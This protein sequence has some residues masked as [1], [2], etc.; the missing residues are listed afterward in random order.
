MWTC[1]KHM[2]FS[3]GSKGSW[4]TEGW[5]PGISETSSAGT[6]VLS[7]GSVNWGRLLPQD[8]ASGLEDLFLLVVIQEAKSQFSKELIPERQ[9]QNDS[10]TPPTTTEE[11]TANTGMASFQGRGAKLLLWQS[12]QTPLALLFLLSFEQILSLPYVSSSEELYR[13]KR[14]SLLPHV[15]GWMSRQETSLI[16]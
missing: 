5:T 13:R 2:Y 16:P 11:S 7:F 14:I 9:F 15:R 3:K 4:S 12:P 10:A 1:L 6:F 8:R